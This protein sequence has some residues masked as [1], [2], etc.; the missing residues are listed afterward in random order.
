MQVN[1]SL[2]GSLIVVMTLAGCSNSGTKPET[3]TTNGSSPA[4]ESTKQT[5]SESTEASQPSTASEVYEGTI[6]GV[7]SDSM[8]GKD[9]SKMGEAGKQPSKC[10][11]QCVA[12][13]AKYVLVDEKGDSY[14][15]SDQEKSK[16]LAGKHVA[17]SGHIDPSE[18][19]IHVHSIVVAA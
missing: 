14:T 13:G 10:I 17:I 16:I 4:I 2:I 12:S 5:A 1:R 8:C 9:H 15:L 6:H 7:I 11:E 19:A 3:S 18:K